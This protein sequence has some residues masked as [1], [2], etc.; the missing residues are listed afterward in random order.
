MSVSRDP[1]AN[2]KQ[3]TRTAIL[4]AALASLSEGTVPTVATTADRA[5]VS[6][7]TAY[8][9]FP[10]QAHLVEALARADPLIV[11]VD[12]V[13]EHLDSQDVGERFAQLQAAYNGIAIREE[14]HM[15][16]TLRTLLD[17]WLAAHRDGAERAA[18]VRAASRQR[19]V[20]AV[21]A[22]LGELDEPRRRRLSAA[23]TLTL[24]IESI[25]TLKDV[26]RLDD[27]DVLDVLAWAAG[28][29]LREAEAAPGA[30]PPRQA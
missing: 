12:E 17:A 16:A 21:L 26:C 14:A 1:R 5:R 4:D 25:I 20:D 23:L 13:V 15:R 8:R 11:A 30:A 10:T 27:E 3:R 24:G 7:A 28:A 29:M 22:P 19:W 9:Y 18:G 2:Q 6:R